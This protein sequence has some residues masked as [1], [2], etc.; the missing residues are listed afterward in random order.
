[1]P[2]LEKACAQDPEHDYGHSLMALAETYGA[3]NRTDQA[4]AAWRQVLASH[5]YAQT[6]VQLAELY[7]T[8]G[9]IDPARAEIHE[10]I[11]DDPHAPTFQRRRDRVWVS[12]AKALARKLGS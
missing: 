1:M 3:L 11:A 9:Q 4:I 6:R 12:R 10:V 8:Q 2:F 7:A 5:N